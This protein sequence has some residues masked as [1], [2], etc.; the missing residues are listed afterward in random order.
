MSLEIEKK[1]LLYPIMIEPFLKIFKLPCKKIDIIQN[2]IERDGQVGR[3]RKFNDRY[4]LTI[5]KGEGL[6]REEYEKEINKNIYENI[7][8]SSNNIKTIYKKRCIVELDG[9]LYEIDEFRGFLRGLVFLEVEFE[10]EDESKHFNLNK[11]FQSILIKEV[12]DDKNFSNENI[13][14]LQK[15]PIIKG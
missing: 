13:A 6:I 1:Y 9:F 12:T 7:I 15:M 11:T 10:S 4:F 8:L 14:N 2:Y 5:K 3:V